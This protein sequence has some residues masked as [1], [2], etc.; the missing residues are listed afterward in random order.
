MIKKNRHLILWLVGLAALAIGI[1]GPGF[2]RSL[3]AQSDETYEGLK[4]FSDVIEL[5][6]KNYVDQVE[7]KKL[8]ED[9]IQGMVSSLDPHSALLTPDA[10][11]ELQI[12]T[13][14][15][16]TGIGIHV[17][18]SNNLVSVIAPIEYTPAYA[19]GI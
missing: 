1:L 18:M 13:Q 16:F 8:I 15:E 12:D 3:S 2:Y 10:Y 14:G 5:I 17:T 6:E 19:A 9:A 4:V 11:K 7:P